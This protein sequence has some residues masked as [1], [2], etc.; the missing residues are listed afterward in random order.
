[1]GSAPRLLSLTA[2]K[3]SWFRGAGIP[4]VL[5]FLL[6]GCAAEVGGNAD[7]LAKAMAANHQAVV[8]TLN[9][10]NDEARPFLIQQEVEAP[11]FS[12]DKLFL[13]APAD[14]AAWDK[15]LAG[16]DNYCAALGNLTSGK[17]SEKYEEVTEAFGCNVQA[18]AKAAKLNPGTVTEGVEAG[19]TELGAIL[20]R[21]KASADAVAIAREADPHFQAVVHGLVEALGFAGRPPE[22]AAHGLLATYEAD[23]AAFTAEQGKKFRDNGIA[24]YET[25]TPAGKKAAIGEFIAWQAT[26]REHQALLDAIKTLAAALDKAAV[27]HGRLAGGSKESADAALAALKADVQNASAIYQTYRKG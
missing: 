2:A 17:A 20:I 18:L 1:M 15:I 3:T 14:V 23:F 10:V 27:A 9:R 7:E 8:A 24:D 13:L 11:A 6:A 21:R 16:L 19:V 4:A 22:P 26:Q 5:I 12:A 25:M